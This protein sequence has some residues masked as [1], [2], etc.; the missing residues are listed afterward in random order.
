MARRGALI[1]RGARAAQRGVS[2]AELL[3][4]AMVTLIMASIAVPVLQSQD[5]VG[6]EVRKLLADA[7]RTRAQARTTWA[8]SVLRAD[9]VTQRWR[10]ELADGTVL[11][12]PEADANGWRS[13]PAGM[14]FAA[15]T[16]LPT[17]F[18]FL[19]NGRGNERAAL[20]IIEGATVWRLEL[21]PLSGSLRTEK[22]G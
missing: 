9:L 10:C 6:G 18:T 21:D 14:R 12:A 15:V 16:G 5:R 13:L 20:L 1:R 8:P 17:L 2:L 3:I 4:V 11:D 22:L 19:P 7:V